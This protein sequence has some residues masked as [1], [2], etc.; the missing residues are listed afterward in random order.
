M[1]ITYTYEGI[2]MYFYELQVICTI[3]VTKVE[4]SCER[5]RYLKIV[6]FHSSVLDVYY[7]HL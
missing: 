3:D 4:N 6:H 2:T 5:M 7:L 1:S